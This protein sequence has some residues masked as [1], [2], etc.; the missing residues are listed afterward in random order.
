MGGS[1]RCSRP[2]VEA[3]GG[4]RDSITWVFSDVMVVWILS[5]TVGDYWSASVGPAHGTTA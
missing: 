1:L 2:R 5:P 4:G 3:A